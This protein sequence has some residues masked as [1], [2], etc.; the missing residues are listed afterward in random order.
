MLG[1]PHPQRHALSNK[2]GFHTFNNKMEFPKRNLGNI[3]I[4]QPTGHSMWLHCPIE[5]DTARYPNA[6]S[7]QHK[8]QPKSICS[9][10][11]I[12]GSINM[13]SN[14]PSNDGR[15]EENVAPHSH[16]EMLLITTSVATSATAQRQYAI[17]PQTPFSTPTV[18][19]SPSSHGTS[20]IQQQS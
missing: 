15:Q 2:I 3:L 12:L 10:Y 5:N 7:H 20:S 19:A 1:S 9:Q 11:I 16:S 6:K 18:P 13:S 8:L 17:T 14:M 4:R